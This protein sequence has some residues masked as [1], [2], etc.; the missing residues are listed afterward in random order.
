M[1]KIGLFGLLVLSMLVS[2]QA[3]ITLS[4]G[5]FPQVGDT[6]FYALDNQPMGILITPSGGAQTWDFT[7]LQPSQI[8][9]QS[10]DDLA[11]GLVSDD[12][13]E[14]NLLFRPTEN[15][16]SYMKVSD[17]TV[18]VLGLN[19]ADPVG[20][21][22]NLVS[23]YN[24]TVVERRA[25]LNFFD[26]NQM[27]AAL[28]LAFSVS[29]L[30][31][32]IL[33]QLPV[34]PDS[35]RIRLSIDRLDLVDGWGTLSI[36]G[37]T[38][39]VL[40]EKRTEFRETR[41]DAKLPLLGWDDITNV[42]IEFLR[43]ESLGK[44]TLVT[45]HFWS[46]EA[47]EPIAVC[48]MDNQEEQVVSVQFKANDMT[49]DV[50]AVELEDLGFRIF[51]NPARDFVTIRMNEL[52]RGDYILKIHNALGEEVLR[53]IFTASG[54]QFEEKLSVANLGGGIYSCQLA[55]DQGRTMVVKQMIIVEE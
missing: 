19:G 8:W 22:L 45:Y 52:S 54:G 14:A 5:N 44:D 36:P 12:F 24:P 20:L 39:E 15:V 2:A 10:Y 34:A 25:P 35:L 6:L 3:Q 17:N 7:S 32:V 16:E 28:L 37:E 27:E 48:T 33:D 13:P 46:N 53:R 23:Q 43:L 38:H 9:K 51:P 29:E 30:P 50:A 41:L 31:Q 55:D 49:T 1:K 21:G 4:N 18:E 11:N 42:A 26:V 47:K 40:R